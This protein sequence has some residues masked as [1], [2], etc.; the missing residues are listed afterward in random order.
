MN[1]KIIIILTIICFYGILL[2]DNTG[3]GLGTTLMKGKSGKVWELSAVTT[4]DLNAG[5]V[6]GVFYPPGAAV[7]ACTNTQ[8]VA[9]TVGTSGYDPEAEIIVAEVNSYVDENMDMLAADIS[10]GKG[11]YIDTL[12]DLMNVEKKMAFKYR[13][14][15]NFN[16]IYT[17]EDITSEEVVKNIYQV[18]YSEQVS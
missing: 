6:V 15:K 9:I 13:L 11:E 4:N 7:A 14:K 16:R 17:R 1:K 12:V 2:A 3:C 10:K 5:G 8:N 18:Y